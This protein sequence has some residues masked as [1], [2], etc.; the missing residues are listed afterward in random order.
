M[1]L[2]KNLW[3]SSFSRMAGRYSTT[4][5]YNKENMPLFLHQSNQ[6]CLI[7]KEAQGK[8]YGWPST[9]L[10]Q[11]SSLVGCLWL[12]F[13]VQWNVVRH[14]VRWHHGTAFTDAIENYNNNNRQ[15]HRTYLLWEHSLCLAI[16]IPTCLPACLSNRTTCTRLHVTRSI[17]KA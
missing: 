8:V 7:E 16:E 10:R 4:P 17:C 11:T 5:P 9:S 3:G 14:E 12:S 15:T 1:K 13:F 2:W 6:L